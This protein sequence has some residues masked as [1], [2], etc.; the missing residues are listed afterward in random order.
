MRREPLQIVL[1]AEGSE[2]AALVDE[3]KCLHDHPLVVKQ[4]LNS[5]LLQSHSKLVDSITNVFSEA[6]KGLLSNFDVNSRYLASFKAS[7]S[8]QV[9]N[10]AGSLLLAAT[11]DERRVLKLFRIDAE[12]YDDDSMT[13][14][15]VCIAMNNRQS[16]SI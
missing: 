11:D 13:F 7:V 12:Q 15:S 3:N 6:Y 10:N 16:N 2:W 8:T 9:V 5:S 1:T 14:K 4:D